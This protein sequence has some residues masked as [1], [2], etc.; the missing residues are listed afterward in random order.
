M[1][2]VGKIVPPDKMAIAEKNGI[3]RTTLYNRLRAGWDLDRAITEP[4]RKIVKIERGEEGTFVGANKAKPR[5]FSLPVEL[6][7]K[8]EK[9]I[10]KSG[11]S[12]SVWLEEEMT[13]KLK[14]MKV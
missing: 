10:K 6:D 2:K 14:R 1:G 5:Y 9:I 8:L 11:K 3:P 7:E 4:S 13:K 12:P